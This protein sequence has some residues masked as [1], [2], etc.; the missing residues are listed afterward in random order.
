MQLKAIRFGVGIALATLLGGAAVVGA[1]AAV[2]EPAPAPAAVTPQ[3]KPI[4][5]PM[6][7]LCEGHPLLAAWCLIASGS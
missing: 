4:G 6:P 7:S 1:G 2:A 5:P 3:A